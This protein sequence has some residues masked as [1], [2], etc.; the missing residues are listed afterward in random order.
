MEAPCGS[1][2]AS[3]GRSRT[4]PET[5][6]DV[7]RREEEEGEEKAKLRYAE[8]IRVLKKRPSS[9]G[10]IPLLGKPNPQTRLALFCSLFLPF[11]PFFSPFFPSPLPPWRPWRR[12]R[13]TPSMLAPPPL[14]VAHFPILL[15]LL[16]LLEEVLDSLLLPR[17]A[18]YPFLVHFPCPVV[19]PRRSFL[20][21]NRVS[22]LVFLHVS[23]AETRVGWAPWGV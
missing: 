5:S 1:H 22:L 23:H 20:G 17:G 19:L 12:Q 3:M 6:R 4:C 9:L 14:V 11:L 18:L 15:P 10:N 2:H 13:T 21:F 16:L 7:W 8:L